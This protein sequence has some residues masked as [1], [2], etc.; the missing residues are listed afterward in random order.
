MKNKI[1]HN[2]SKHAD[3][4]NKYATLQRNNSKK[5]VSFLSSSQNNLSNGPIL[6]IGCGTGFV[7][8]HLLNKFPGKEMVISDISS[9]MVELCKQYLRPHP[10]CTESIQF[11]VVDGESQYPASTYALIISGYTFQWFISFEQSIT[12]LIDALLPG[13]VL[14]FSLLVKN[15]FSEWYALCQSLD[16]PFTGNKLPDIEEIK[17]LRVWDLRN[18]H[19]KLEQDRLIYPSIKDFLQSLKHIGAGTL[20]HHKS[21]SS[22]QMRQLLRSQEPDQNGF[23]ITYHTAYVLYKKPSG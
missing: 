1:S 8:E 17:S 20:T 19:I 23:H 18:L 22:A 2:F 16:I 9:R 15:T 6:E 4:Y 21:L 13:G 14:L 7:S 11:Q 5:L 10:H 12:R 3:T